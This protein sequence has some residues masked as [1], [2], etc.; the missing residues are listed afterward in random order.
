MSHVAL[1]TRR[2]ERHD[3]AGVEHAARVTNLSLCL[4]A[5][6]GCGTRVVETLR[7]G[8]PLHDIGKL[9]VDR[10][11]LAKP[12]ALEPEEVAEIRKHP[13]AGANLL[14]GIRSLQGALD[15]VLHHH[16]RW[17][18]GGYPHGLGGL[19]ISEEA[20]ILAVADAYDAMTSDRPY[21][22]ALTHAEA[23]AEV[24]RCAGTQFDPLV[25]D[26]FLNLDPVTRPRGTTGS[27]R[28]RAS[29]ASG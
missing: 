3:P 20:R 1:L 11:I 15:T 12:A 10:S 5:V 18:G 27:T 19:E 22:A 13:V 25:A 4:A 6:L 9:E 14:Q 21:R 23:V 16:E 26:A 29:S 17:D 8:G 2:L 24:E 7:A 28:P